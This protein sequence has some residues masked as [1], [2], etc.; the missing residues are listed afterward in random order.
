MTRFI[1]PE[2]E[3]SETRRE[4]PA[5]PVFRWEEC[6]PAEAEETKFLV[7]GL[8]PARGSH[9][10]IGQPKSGKSQLLGHLVAC[11]I[12]GEDVFGHYEAPE[13]LDLEI[14]WIMAEETRYQPRERVEANLRGLGHSE[15][16]IRSLMPRFGEAVH[17]SA[18]DND[19]ERSLQDVCFSIE[20]HGEWLQGLLSNGQ[21]DVV[22][23]DSLRPTHRL[24]ENSSTEMQP[25]TSLMRTLSSLGCFIA[26]HH[27]GHRSEGSSRYG[28]DAARGTSDLDAARD[29]AIQVREG[30]FGGRML[31]GFHHRYEAERFVAVRTSVQ[32]D[33]EGELTT[34]WEFLGEGEEAR[35]AKPRLR[36]GELFDE[37]DAA[38]DPTELPNS[39]WTKKIFYDGY[40][41]ELEALEE[42]GII[43]L[44][45]LPNGKPGPNPT[46]VCRPRQ[47]TDEEWE[48]AEADLQAPGG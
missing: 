7:E 2:T 39:S 35:E 13:G 15:E 44:R 4:P 38:N 3:K 37:I 12:T 19:P 25:V 45:T 18:R 27:T 16:E 9:L 23:V 47:F 30:S 6:D 8:L 1:T 22:I 43:E 29:S 32:E 36:L 20:R 21:Y 34:R 11:L 14:L 48:A 24:E 28:G 41:D 10:L 31:L 33:E 17:V 5:P 42:K 46:L 26:V 40:S